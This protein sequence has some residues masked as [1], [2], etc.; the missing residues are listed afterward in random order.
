MT[1]TRHGFMSFIYVAL[2]LCI[3]CAQVNTFVMATSLETP[4]SHRHS[5]Q[6]GSTW[7]LPQQSTRPTETILQTLWKKKKWGI[8]TRRQRRHILA[9]KMTDRDVN[10]ESSSTGLESQLIASSSDT[11][12][13][14]TAMGLVEDTCPRPSS[15]MSINVLM[16]L[17]YGTLGSIMPYLPIF[18]RKIGATGKQIHHLSHSTTRFFDEV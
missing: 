11:T 14:K 13:S 3:I 12:D 7:S 16:L 4:S 17:F 8:D 1:V 2:V 5:P 15:L 6:R 18:Y 10:S 9:V